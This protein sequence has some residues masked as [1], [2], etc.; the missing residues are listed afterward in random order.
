MDDLYKSKGEVQ[1]LLYALRH[2]ENLD[3][4]DHIFKIS[5]RYYLNDHFQLARFNN[6]FNQWCLC[7]DRYAT[8]LYKIHRRHLTKYIG[9]LIGSLSHIELGIEVAMCRV[10]PPDDSDHQ[11]VS[12]VGVSGLIAVFNNYLIHN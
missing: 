10:Y 8:T 3:R 4:F 11:L 9:A 2:L 5:G 12:E 1:L 7:G 6:D